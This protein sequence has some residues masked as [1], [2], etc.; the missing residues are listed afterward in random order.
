MTVFI[1]KCT[2]INKTCRS[3]LIRLLLV[4]ELKNYLEKKDI[5]FLKMEKDF[6][7]ENNI[8]SLGN[9]LIF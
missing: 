8:F 6:K 7:K 9:K 1:I 4:C 5:L 2:Y 3:D